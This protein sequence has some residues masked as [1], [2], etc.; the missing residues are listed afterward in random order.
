MPCGCSMKV[1]SRWTQHIPRNWTES[2][3]FPTSVPLSLATVVKCK[4]QVQPLR[5]TAA[6]CSIPH[7]ADFCLTLLLRRLSSIAGLW[8]MHACY[9]LRHPA[10]MFAMIFQSCCLPLNLS[11]TLVRLLCQPCQ[12]PVYLCYLGKDC[13]SGLMSKSASTLHTTTKMDMGRHFNWADQEVATPC[14]KHSQGNV[15][16]FHFQFFSAQRSNFKL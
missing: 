6:S 9:L 14:C 4:L 13:C 16:H 15:I 8:S 12:R 2:G 11:P 10:V 3:L 5:V 7:C 1:F